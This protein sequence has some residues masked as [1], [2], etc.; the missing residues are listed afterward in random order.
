MHTQVF[1]LN[2]CW[3]ILFNIECVS[4]SSIWRDNIE[5][6]SAFVVLKWYRTII[7]ARVVPFCSRIQV[8][9]WR[10]GGSVGLDQR[11]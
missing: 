2:V 11:G 4:F 10:S 3:L 1:C 7:D 9:A 8:A 5:D 6:C